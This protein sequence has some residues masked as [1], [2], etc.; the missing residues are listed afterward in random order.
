MTTSRHMKH[1]STDVLI[2]GSGGA[3]LQAAIEAA[4]HNVQ[5][6]L[7][8]KNKAGQ[9]NC[10]AAA[11]GSLRIS[12]GAKE[13]EHHFQETLEAG[14]FLNN[15]RLVRTLATNAW[16]A[17]QKLDTL[18]VPLRIERGKA[19]ILA[20]RPAGP[21]MTKTLTDCALHL[22]VTIL[23]K[24]TVF[25]LPV[26]E[27]QCRGALA[28]KK[29]TGELFV[30]S[31]KATVLATGGYSQLYTRN[32]NPSPITGDGIVLAY[33]AGAN[34]Q[35]LEFIQFQPTF[36]DKGVPQR[37]ILDWLIEAT[38]QLVPGGPLINNKGERFLSSY[39]LM[40]SPILRDNLIVA[41]ER[42]ILA[43][44][45][46]KDS[47]I[48]NLTSLSPEDIE[49]A[50]DLEF[51]KSA[52]RPFLRLLSTRPLHIASSAHYTMGG[53]SIDETCSTTIEG[54]YAAGEVTGGVHGAN[55]L[56]GN[57]LTE[58]LVFG[59]IA[60]QNAAHH[61]HQVKSSRIDEGQIKRAK[62]YLQDLSCDNP[63]PVTPSSLKKE[64]RAIVS[65]YCR[66]VRIGDEL[67][68]AQEAL[69]HIQKE[70]APG[71]SASTPA[72]LTAAIEAKGMLLLAQLLVSASLA[73]RESRGA[74]F[75]IDYPHSDDNWLKNII[76]TQKD[77]KVKISYT[78][79]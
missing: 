73:R 17:V 67:V 18:G 4:S 41:I 31:S 40:Q 74:H 37:P 14:R 30:I 34:L 44:Q 79:L 29:D 42:E 12:Q 57:A 66:P 9:A 33:N 35:D 49:D 69:F 24:T 63:H 51:Q 22:G 62:A 38:K 8:T 75:R 28:L 1:L 21:L 78:T 15:T 47:V 54:L 46:Q 19:S 76:L 65:H 26:E 56:G 6:L 5:V 70:K 7:V 43:E 27:G 39:N 50:F 77:N 61:A 64:V 23:E 36:I 2:I 13:S 53:V 20:E 10:T 68:R 60:G 72:H 59:A 3:G 25:S 52:A 48:C 32:D 45:Q 11:M 71:L 58:I 55:R 16:S